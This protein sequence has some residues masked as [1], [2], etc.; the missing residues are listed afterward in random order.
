MHD[1]RGENL[2]GFF[3][4]LCGYLIGLAQLTFGVSNW[5]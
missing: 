5:R 1:G 4:I 2:F 3:V